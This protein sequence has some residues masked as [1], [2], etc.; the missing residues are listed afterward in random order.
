MTDRN[1]NMTSD[2]SEA[3]D[4]RIDKTPD[5]KPSLGKDI[6]E[7]PEKKVKEAVAEKMSES[8]KEN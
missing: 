5:N 1:K 7:L 2:M 8:D 4:Q 6:K 3:S